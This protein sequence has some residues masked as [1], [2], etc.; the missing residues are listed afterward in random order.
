MAAPL[1]IKLRCASWQ[2]LSAIYKRDLS[3]S[4]MFLRSAS[5]PPLGTAV[6]I[7]LTLPSDSMIV[8]SPDRIETLDAIQFD[9]GAK[10]SISKASF[11][12][13]G[14]IG[15]TMRAHP[16]IIRMRV[17]VHVHPSGNYDKDQDVS[18]KRAQAIRDWLVQYG[19]AAARVEA[20]G[21]GSSKPLAQDGQKG[22]AD[23]NNRVELIILE[24]K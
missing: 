23:I 5:P 14:Q 11:N 4:A 17:T 21:F 12:V 10:V 8:L 6:R 1:S 9:R 13:L 20:R 7:D 2:Q 19:I 15:A 22:A 16:E 3:R 24:R 18:D